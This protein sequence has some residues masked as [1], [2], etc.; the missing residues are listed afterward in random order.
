MD[1]LAK[2]ILSYDMATYTLAPPTFCGVTV[3]LLVPT[4]EALGESAPVI[5]DHVTNK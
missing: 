2:V 3:G 5:V 1:M 4:A